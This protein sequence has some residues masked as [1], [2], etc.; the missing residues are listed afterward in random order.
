MSYKWCLG[1]FTKNEKSFEGQRN[2]NPRPNSELEFTRSLLLQ[3]TIPYMEMPQAGIVSQVWDFAFS[4]K[5]GRDYSVGCSIMWAERDE[6]RNGEKTG[7]R[8]IVGYVQEVVRDRFNHLTLAKAIVELASKYRPF[9]VGVENAAGSNLLT[10]QIRVEALRTNNPH[11]AQVCGNI[12]WF[13][14]DNQKDAKKVRM[15]STY[16]W[17]VEGRLK[18]YNGCFKDKEGHVNLE[19]LYNEFERCLTS[20]HHDDI[21]DVI[22]MQLRYAPKV[23]IVMATNYDEYVSR[24]D[25]M[26][27]LIFGETDDPFGR[28]GF[29]APAPVLTDPE[30]QEEFLQAETPDGLPNVLGAGLFG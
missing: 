18:L 7:N 16:P 9:I 26:A 13:S 5:K 29:G 11:I 10:E 30:I 4:K 17:F 6:I 19:P 2:Q 28:I 21:P 12:D 27:N 24:N 23:Q 1:D 8:V 14:P 3:N 15:R 25:P 20:H 22:A